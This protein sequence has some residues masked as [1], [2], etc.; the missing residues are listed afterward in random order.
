MRKKVRSGVNEA[1]FP[2]FLSGVLLLFL[3]ALSNVKQGSTKEGKK[4]LEQAIRRT[5]ITCYATEGIYPPD[6]EYLKEHY[7]IRINEERYTVVYTVFAENIMP[8][9]TV[10][11]KNHEE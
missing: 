7:G 10:L 3:V 6:I 9:I 5:V 1:L 8:D 4:Q 11:E 2:V